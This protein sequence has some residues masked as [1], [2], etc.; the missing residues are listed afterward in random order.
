MLVYEL[1]LTEKLSWNHIVFQ[2]SKFA[3]KTW[4]GG[5]KLSS[6]DFGYFELCGVI[7]SVTFF[8]MDTNF[9]DEIS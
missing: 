8:D 1:T 6:C 2:V 4:Y 5:L 9:E 3:W 7:V